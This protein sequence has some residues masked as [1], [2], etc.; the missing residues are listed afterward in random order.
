MNAYLEEYS[1]ADAVKRYLN[2]TAGVG[3]S[4]LLRNIY[5]PIYQRNV[6]I[7]EK[8]FGKKGW[9]VLEYGCGGGMNLIHVT[10]LLGER[11]IEV[12]RAHGTD[13]AQAMID[14]ANRE[15]SNYLSPAEQEKVHFSVVANENLSNGLSAEL[16]VPQSDVL[17]SF[18]FIFGI[19]TFR[20][21]HRIGKAEQTAK[22]IFRLLKPGGISMMIDMNN[23]FP[24]F[25][26]RK[27]DLRT[28]PAEQCVLPT[29][30]EYKGP[31]E[32]AG[33][34]LLE[35]KNFCWIP[36][37]ASG[38]TFTITKMLNPL[39]DVMVPSYAMRTL[40]IGQKP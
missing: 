28:K 12:E 25:R 1:Q 20:Y 23:K 33:F 10:K 37:S 9:R 13:F 4:H 26:S 11:G 29:V 31:F 7:L 16:G 5:G 39:L 17:N 8:K 14:A 18:H 6:D 32:R 36:H 34:K 22:D 40:V 3:I 2:A 30:D 27:E 38:M 19:N 21:C 24:F 35:V 15:A